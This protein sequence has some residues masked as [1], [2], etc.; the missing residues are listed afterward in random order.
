MLLSIIFHFITFTDF[1]QQCE[2]VARRD[3]EALEHGEAI[4]RPLTRKQIN[5]NTRIKQLTEELNDGL[6]I[7]DF[8]A[9][10]SHC[11]EP[12]V[13]IIISLIS[14]VSNI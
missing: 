10:S 5:Q 11:F 14:F 12:A 13:V 3:F 6:S 2:L 9:R 8:L 7:E 1:L 4:R